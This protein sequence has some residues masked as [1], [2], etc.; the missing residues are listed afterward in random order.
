MKECISIKTDYSLL[1]SLIK[2]PDLIS[3]ALKNDITSLGIID[4]NLSSS[5]EFILE[6]QKNNIKPIIGL[7]T[8]LNN[9]ST[10]LYAKSEKGLK[11]LFKLNTFLLDNELDITTLTQYNNDIL[12]VLPINSISLYDELKNIALVFIGY[13]NEE[14]KIKSLAISPNVVFFNITLSLNKEDTKYLNYLNMIK[15]NLS[16]DDYTIK[17]Y[18]SNY[19]K[20]EDCSNFTKLIKITL[21]PSK[22][23]I[24][25]YDN[26]IENSYKYL[27][28]LAVKG[29]NKRLNGNIPDSYKERLIYELKIIKEM[30]FTDYFLIVYDY[31]K[32]AKKN[33]IYVGP[34]RGSAAGSLTTYSL[35][36]TSIDPLK[37]GLLFERFLN[38]QRITMPDIDIDFD[39]SKR[40]EV[41]DYV[42]TK[43]G[44][45]NVMPIM[46]Y[47]TMAT[48]QSLLSVSKILNT[49]ISTLNKLIDPQKSLKDNL[50]PEVIKL[51]NSNYDLKK[52]YY[53]ALKL[54][55]I[56]KHISTHA[57]GVVICAKPLDSVIP[58]AK[59]G[60][61]YLTGY[62]MNYLENLGLLKMDFLAIKDLTSIANILEIIPDK[63]NLDNINL[64][65]KEVLDNFTNANTTGIFQFESEGM[66]GFL[67]K[68]KP[69]TF[70]DL[71]VALALY[72]PGPMENIPLFIKRKEGKAK[73]DYITPSLEPILKETYG[74][75][76]YQ[77][78]IMKIFNVIAS[79]SVAEAD[80]IR[81]AISKKKENVILEEKENFILRASKNGYS[82]EISTKIY[83]LILKFANYGFN[84]SHSVAYALVA[85][86]M[87]Y[88]KVKYPDYFYSSLLNININ[89]I[90][91]TKEYLDEAKRLNLKIIKP[92]INLSKDVYYIN[93]GI[94]MPL[95]SIRNI[96][97][98][99][100]KEISDE[101][102]KG[103]YADFF[104]FVAR[105]YGKSINIKT[106]ESLIYAG[107]LD[108]LNETRKTLIE[109][110]KSA[111]IYA[112]LI[113]GLDSSL[114]AKPSL[115][116]FT[117]YPLNELISKELDLY[118]FYVSNHPASK[119]KV[120][121]IGDIAKYF[122]KN[123]TTVGLLENI[124]TIKTKKG[125][126]MAFLKIS[127]ETGVLNYTL[128]P[129]R[130][131]Y[132]NHIKCGDILSINGHVEKRLDKYQIVIN[133]IEIVK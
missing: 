123:I 9:L 82:T 91:K 124:S 80:L 83:N 63:I 33:N 34:G 56:K 62:T 128:F 108:S 89:S 119:Y 1:T 66:K 7:H 127:D 36:I 114:V 131:S 121:K 73:I 126:T 22:N 17:D 70:E 71:V 117:E 90:G 21:T 3:Y 54:E 87:M 106:I 5:I 24:P 107:A 92:D 129:N 51:L 28:T 61:V 99:T 75:I 60:D 102:A 133:K 96:G 85:Y 64:N 113:S 74:I 110:I 125:D 35:G 97:S 15:D 95:S 10:Y 120:P 84:K 31:V 45:F 118:G 4:D 130:I 40:G 59:S 79:Y 94:I 11:D 101:L 93:N 50:T 105:T 16:K 29:L 26:N 111:Q 19:L 6:C 122:D 67:T 32:Y 30:N 65:L 52:V 39:A 104:D 38:P 72:R 47:G 58:I 112:E 109:N 25:H 49:N 86:Q 2:V 42:K 43:Y 77:E 115:E 88:L 98:I 14:E 78:Q 18:S 81:K 68:L 8:K 53:D 76:V 20:W 55:G 132:I 23:L 37:Y 100:A 46:T 57:A 27:E 116:R 13:K 44:K 103:K 12:I 48:K 41:I 69:T